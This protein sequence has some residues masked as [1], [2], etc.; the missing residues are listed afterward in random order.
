MRHTEPLGELLERE[1]CLEACRIWELVVT[2]RRRRSTA[3]ALV[4]VAGRR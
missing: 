1:D 2:P 4:R 3:L